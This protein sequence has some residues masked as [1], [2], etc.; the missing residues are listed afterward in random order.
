MSRRLVIGHVATVSALTA[1][2]P[3]AVLV[4]PGQGGRGCQYKTD[5]HGRGS[6]CGRCGQ[7]DRL[8]AAR[9]EARGIGSA[10]ARQADP[11]RPR[12]LPPDH[13]ANLR[14]APHRRRSPRESRS[15]RGFRHGVVQRSAPPGSAQSRGSRD[16]ELPCELLDDR[17]IDLASGSRKPSSV[18]KERQQHGEAEPVAIMLGHDE[19]QVRGRQCR[20]LRS[21]SLVGDFQFER[22]GCRGEGP[23]TLYKTR[24]L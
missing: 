4:L 18:A 16:G 5:H 2:A 22:V 3:P 1:A 11:K 24:I 7:Y 20:S 23:A 6:R 15:G 21:H 14:A 9:S 10:K 12:R 17:R 13:A 19:R 8:W